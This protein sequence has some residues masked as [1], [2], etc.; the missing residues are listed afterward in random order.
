V[1]LLNF[2]LSK[3]VQITF[4]GVYLSTVV[5]NPVLKSMFEIQNVLP[6]FSLDLLLNHCCGGGHLPNPY[7]NKSNNFYETAVSCGVTPCSLV[8]V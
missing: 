2:S 6:V 8:D 1:A 7:M 4:H 5:W 3:K